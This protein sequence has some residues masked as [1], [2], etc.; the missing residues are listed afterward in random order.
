VDGVRVRAVVEP[1]AR[2]PATLKAQRQAYRRGQTPVRDDDGTV[3]ALDVR[4]AGPETAGRHLDQIA[5]RYGAPGLARSIHGLTATRGWSFAQVAVRHA[6]ASVQRHGTARAVAACSSPAA[7]TG[8]QPVF[9]AAAMGQ[10]RG[11]GVPSQVGCGLPAAASHSL[12]KVRVHNDPSAHAVARALRARAVTVGRSIYMGA[13]EYQPSTADGRRLLAHEIAHTIQQAGAAVSPVEQLRV[14]SPS[15]AEEVEADSF[16]G[17]VTAGADDVPIPPHRPTSTAKLL[18]AITF[19]TAN[20]VVTTSDPGVSEDAATGTFKIADGF[21]TRPH[22]HWS[23]DVTIHG[24]AGDKFADWQAGPLQ[25]IRDHW[26]NVWW[27]NGDQR[28]HRK[29]TLTTPVRDSLIGHT[30]TVDMLASAPFGKDGD[31]RNVRQADSPGVPSTPIA[32]PLPDRVSTRGWFNFGSAFVTYISAR[33]T[34]V[35]KPGAFRHLAHVYWNLS[36]DGDFDAAREAGAQVRV[37]SAAT[38]AGGVVAGE[39][40]A[41]P[42]I[43]GGTVANIASDVTTE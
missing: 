7:T 20:D 28:T 33:D 36:I 2:N 41:D 4:P 26:F 31:V 42:P 12:G 15:D 43:I 32:N 21:P 24:N 3:R 1:H 13:G 38:N 37:G 5:E 8:E 27:D 40:A 18:R 14:S 23:E 34:S 29:A 22:F 17:R 16:A 11:V 9:L 6:S 30:W 10:S 39:S 19:T 25:L 35:P